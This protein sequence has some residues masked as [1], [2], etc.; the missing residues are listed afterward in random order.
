MHSITTLALLPFPCEVASG[1]PPRGYEKVDGQFGEPLQT[2]IKFFP[3]ENLCYEYV[4]DM[5]KS[6]WTLWVDTIAK[7]DTKIPPNAEFSQ[8]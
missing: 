2:W 1:K 3:E 5:A 4:F 7:E 8:V 6:K